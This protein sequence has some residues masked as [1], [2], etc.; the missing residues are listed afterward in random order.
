[1]FAFLRYQRFLGLTDLLFSKSLQRYVR[2]KTWGT[3]FAH[4]LVLSLS[5]CKLIELL[6]TMNVDYVGVVSSVGK[7]FIH[8]INVTSAVTDLMINLWLRFTLETQI[9]LLNRLT[10]LSKRQQ[11]DTLTLRRSRWFI[12]QWI[13][14]SI[15]QLCLISYYTISTWNSNHQILHL[16]ALIGYFQHLL[17]ANYVITCY[18]S[19]VYIVGR[20]LQAQ[21]YQLKNKSLI[22][23]VELTDCLDIH[24]QLLMLIQGEMLHVFGVVLIFPYI[25]FVLDAT[26]LAYISTFEDRFSYKEVIMELLWMY[27]LFLYMIM[28]LTINEVANQVRKR[29]KLIVQVKNESSQIIMT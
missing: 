25:C 1:M 7:L 29:K 24:D 20:L 21:A 14:I 13:S 3:F 4:L 15:L 23:P 8:L 19:L 18:T 2:H 22:S 16:F 27:P 26:C 28:P 5:A 9:I 10:D 11:L 17:R 6:I 12:R